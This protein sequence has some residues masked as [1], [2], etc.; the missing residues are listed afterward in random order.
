VAEGT[1][2]EQ[3]LSKAIHMEI[4]SRD[5]YRELSEGI[6]NR[7]GQKQMRRL[8][9]Q[10]EDHRKLLVSRFRRL[11]DKE[12]VQ[13]P[14]YPKDPK[15]EASRDAVYDQT[16]ALEVVSVGIAGE[17]SAI[18]FYS[19]QLDQINALEDQKLLKK[20]VKFEESHLEKLQKIY[21]RLERHNYWQS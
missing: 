4:Y 8:S 11:F 2:Q 20:L 5:F 19:E 3:I 10:E 18:S 14:N 1:W 7:K 15:M 13:D 17:N 12:F 16:T 9:D 6:R 21:G